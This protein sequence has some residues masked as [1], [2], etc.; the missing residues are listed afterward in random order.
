MWIGHALQRKDQGA[1]RSY[2]HPKFTPEPSCWTLCCQGLCAATS[3]QVPV[4]L[5]PSL[6][7][8]HLT[9]LLTQSFAHSTY[10]HLLKTRYSMVHED[11]EPFSFYCS[12]ALTA[13]SPQIL[14]S[15]CRPLWQ[16]LSLSVRESDVR[17]IHLT[18]SLLIWNSLSPHIFI[19]PFPHV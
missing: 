8:S 7:F 10:T 18:K 11:T 16:G 1:L 15:F 4:L 13:V 17:V 5:F 12:L 19:S 6:C 9:I 2:C 3:V 14:P